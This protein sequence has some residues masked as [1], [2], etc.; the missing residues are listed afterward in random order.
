ME[1]CRVGFKKNYSVSME[2]EISITYITN[3]PASGK[4]SKINTILC[5]LAKKKL[6]VIE[7]LLQNISFQMYNLWWHWSIHGT[8][9]GFSWECFAVLLS[10]KCQFL[11]PGIRL[12]TQHLWYGLCSI[13]IRDGTG[14]KFLVHFLLL[15]QPPLGLENFPLKYQIFPFW[16][17]KISSVRVKNTWVLDGLVSYFTAGQKY[18]WGGL[19]FNTWK[20]ISLRNGIGLIQ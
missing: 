11:L 10:S 2:E 14:S 1:V 18:A 12:E 9:N 16:V 7:C 20:H 8:E 3:T 19:E 5:Y 6:F 13:D 15:G 17:K 4:S